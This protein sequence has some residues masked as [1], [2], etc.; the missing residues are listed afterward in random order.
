M[1]DNDIQ[2]QKNV[3]QNLESI[4]PKN[5]MDIQL[6]SIGKLPRITPEQIVGACAIFDYKP[7]NY[8]DACEA[9]LIVVKKLQELNC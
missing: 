3:L 5:I 7:V 6:N 8:K 1:T 4:L 9:G 2:W